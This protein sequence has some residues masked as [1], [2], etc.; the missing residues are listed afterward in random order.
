MTRVLKLCLSVVLLVVGLV[1]CN[2]G[3][4]DTGNPN[5]SDKPPAVSPNTAGAGPSLGQLIGAYSR[6]QAEVA[7]LA[8][9]GAPP[10]VGTPP[11]MDTTALPTCSFD[12][13]KSQS[14]TLTS[15]PTQIVLNYFLDYGAATDTILATYN[16]KTGALA[17]QLTD[18]AVAITSCS[19]AAKTSSTG[20][21]ITLQCK[22]RASG[23]SDCQVTFN[24]D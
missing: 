11:P 20:I 5:I 15:D 21:S 2:F 6:P 19:G 13:Q 18:P 8:P 7:S 9:G 3:V 10:P 16:S 4:T 14:I 12:S 23:G 22:A 17:F 1:G 24:K